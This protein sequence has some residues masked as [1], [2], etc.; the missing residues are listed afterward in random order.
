VVVFSTG[1]TGGAYS[2]GGYLRVGNY[3]FT[4]SAITRVSVSGDPVLN[5]TNSHATNGFLTVEPLTVN[6][7]LSASDKTFDGNT[8]VTLSTSISGLS[9][10]TL[11]FDQV[12][13]S[14]DSA[15]VG[16]DKTVTLY[17]VQLLGTDAANYRLASPTLTTLASILA[18]PTP[19]PEPN[20]EPEPNPGP[21]PEPKP[22]PFIPVINPSLPNGGGGGFGF[23]GASPVDGGGMAASL[24]NPFQLSTDDPGQCRADNLEACGCD[25]TYPEPD[26]DICYQRFVS[27][28]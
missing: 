2:S 16:Q 18:L 28:P 17:G 9:G 10:D 22:S 3:Q 6:P 27:M 25:S 24:D 15:S 20:P 5:F 13:A 12:S 23:G 7:T 8:S 11:D 26:L 4:Q 1:I 21:T 19:A 14:F